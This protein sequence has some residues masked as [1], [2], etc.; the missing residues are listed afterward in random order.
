LASPA[1]QLG[2]PTKNKT[3]YLMGSFF[4]LL[5]TWIGLALWVRQKKR[6]HPFFLCD[7]GCQRL[8]GLDGTDGL[9]G[10]GSRVM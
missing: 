2:L 9:D 5:N 1:G 8:D 6:T 7:Y 4:E 10:S 3:F